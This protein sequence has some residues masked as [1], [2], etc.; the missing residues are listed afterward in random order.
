MKSDGGRRPVAVI[1]GGFSGTMTAVQLARR[2]VPV[3]LAEGQGR[4]GRGV[5][6]STAEPA[7]LLNVRSGNMSAWPDRPD[8]FKLWTGDDGEA[9]VQRREFGRYLGNILDA[10]DGIER[11]ESACVEARRE[12]EGWRLA[13]AD[14]SVAEADALVL[15]NGNQPPAPMA[16]GAELPESLFVNNPWSADAGAALARVAEKGGDVLV[17]GTGLTMV[18]TILSLDE[19][20]FSGRILALS[21]RG[22]E[23]RA[24]APHAAMKAMRDELPQGLLPLWRWVRRRA[25]EGDWRGAVDSLRPYSR[26]LWHGLSAAERRRFLRH[27]RPW[28]DV[29][30]HRI[31]PA[32]AA[33]LEALVEAGRLEIMAGRVVS[34]AEEDGAI[35]AVIR[36]RGESAAVE[37]DFAL[38]VNCTGPL[39][40]LSRTE[41]PLLRQ[42]L[43]EGE[44]GADAFDMGLAVGEDG[45]AGERIW[46]VG[47]M[48]KGAHW[49][50]VAVP[51]IRGQAAE[52]AADIKRELGK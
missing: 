50:I 22:L 20:G 28:W 8:D 46:A 19:A 26:E 43:A 12:G 10:T 33:R 2:G 31:A 44:V 30:R 48:T 18:D 42:L 4:A 21:R 6:Y 40:Q 5:A 38:A 24:H 14:G 36:P 41:D 35:R 13:F 1:G 25:R 47:P 52:V 29:H 15:A 11:R 37:R 45:R 51:D 23:P 49:E 9:F 32:V 34:L 7:H 16:V 27:A 39:G 3:L 17:L